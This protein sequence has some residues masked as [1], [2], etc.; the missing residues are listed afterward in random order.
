MDTEAPGTVEASIRQ[1]LDS[2]LQP[3][4][5]TIVNDSWKHRHHAPMREQ[6]GN[7]GETHFSILVVSNAFQGMSLTQR[8]RMI[9]SALSEEFSAGLHALSLKAKTEDEESKAPS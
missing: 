9:Y 5:L 6:A 4:S 7:N 1:K 8:H 3:T 2:L